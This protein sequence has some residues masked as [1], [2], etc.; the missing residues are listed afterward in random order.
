MTKKT[1]FFK[2]IIIICF[3]RLFCLLFT[4]LFCFFGTFSLLCFRFIH[5]DFFTRGEVK[6]ITRKSY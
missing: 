2:K 4:C 3:N 5:A 6:E 1:V